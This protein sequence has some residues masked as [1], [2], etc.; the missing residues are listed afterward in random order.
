MAVKR[1]NADVGDGPAIMRAYR[2]PGHPA[3]LFFDAD[4]QETARLVGPQPEEVI[5][6]ELQK[7]LTDR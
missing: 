7:I 4:G 2:L 5:K 1:V 6:A 3:L